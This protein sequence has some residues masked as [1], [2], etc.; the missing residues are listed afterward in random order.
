M[1]L[2][3]IEFS[4][5][6]YVLLHD[7][8]PV[9]PILD[10]SLGSPPC[11]LFYGFSDKAHYDTFSEKY[12]LPLTPYP[13]VKVHLENVKERAGGGLKL[14]SL[15]A[16]GPNAAEVMAATNDEVLNAHIHHLSHV[17]STYRLILNPESQLYHVEEQ[18]DWN[19][20][21]G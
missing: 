11:S 15:D 13:L 3:E 14:V 7:R 17:S 8:K 6:Y 9:E 10:S 19:V 2:I 1:N 21:K 4:T 18:G 12:S 5:P 20:E 16:T